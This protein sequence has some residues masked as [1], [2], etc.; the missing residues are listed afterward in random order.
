MN[1]QAQSSTLYDGRGDG[2]V[3][4][5]M[6][7]SLWYARLPCHAGARFVNALWSVAHFFTGDYFNAE[8]IPVLFEME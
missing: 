4:R 5:A 6:T 2:L 8:M 3:I 1:Q 7:V